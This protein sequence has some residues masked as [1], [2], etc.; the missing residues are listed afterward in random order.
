MRMSRV[1]KFRIWDGN[2]IIYITDTYTGKGLLFNDDEYYLV[3]D[4]YHGQHRVKINSLMQ[5]TGLLDKN[6]VEIYEGD[7]IKYDDGNYDGE[8]NWMEN[9]V[10]AEVYYNENNSSFNDGLFLF[11]DIRDFE[12]IGNIH[13]N[14]D[15]V[16]E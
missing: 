1:I 13:Q 8:E 16:T 7:I 10:S 5:F 9:I 2:K 3:D 11:N 12:V 15:L 14:P 4:A 6:G